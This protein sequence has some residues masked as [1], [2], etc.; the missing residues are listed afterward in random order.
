MHETYGEQVTFVGVA[1]RDEMSA[2]NDFV[3]NRGVSDFQ[4][5]FDDRLDVWRAF[6]VNSQ[7]AW[8]F[9]D[10]QG[11]A[12]TLVAGLGEDGLRERVEALIAA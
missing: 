5:V 4:H 9:I 11:N 2:V 10:S 8:V 1:G 6:G 12:E 3:E 7:P